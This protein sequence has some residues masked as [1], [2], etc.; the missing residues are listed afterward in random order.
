MVK[1]P[2]RQAAKAIE[3]QAD[4]PTKSGFRYYIKRLPPSYRSAA[5]WSVPELCAQYSWPKNAPGG[6]VIAIIEMGGGW[7]ESDIDRF[8]TVAR[9]PAPQITDVS[10]DGT[11]NSVCDPR[12]SADGEVALDIQVAGAAYTVATGKPANIR[13][14]WSQDITKAIAAATVDGC[15]V[16]LISW[17]ADE[18]TWGQAAGLALEQAAAAASA[19]GM[20]V[21]AASGDNDSSDG[22]PARANVD[23]PASAP[24]VVG[25]GGTQKR[26]SSAEQ[27]WN[28]DPGQTIGSGTG[29]GFS[30]LFLMPPWQ[31][32]AP[33]GPGRMVP[34]VAAN[35][36]PETG[37]AIVL[38]DSSIVVGGTSASAALY[39]GLFA[40]F[41][42]KIGFITP[43]LYLNSV[44][45]NNIV[46]G[47]NGYFRASPNPDP[48]TGLGSPRASRLEAYFAARRRRDSERKLYDNAITPAINLV[49]TSGLLRSV[50]LDEL[51]SLFVGARLKTLSLKGDSIFISTSDGVCLSIAPPS[52]SA[53]VWV[54][55]TKDV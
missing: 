20:I 29:G 5:T 42:T 50:A 45:F 32:G 35:A 30:T 2:R 49:T 28:N 37:Y 9:L 26:G 23:L 22:G 13:V 46:E 44:C 39:A 11:K 27:V 41:G 8:F 40:S 54:V 4:E 21:F 14:Y 10:V 16:C 55:D 38:Y 47:D 12:N 36:D 24:H 3:S 1:N 48:C 17:G 53:S 19:A 31:A 6:G 51:E 7:L 33:H 25:C 15:D 18:A 52:N 43:D 34:D